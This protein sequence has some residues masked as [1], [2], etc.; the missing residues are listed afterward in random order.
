MWAE[1]HPGNLRRYKHA[2]GEVEV[3][4]HSITRIWAWG[5]STH[6][7]I[8]QP[9]LNGWCGQ[10]NFTA[11]PFFFLESHFILGGPGSRGPG[12]IFFFKFLFAVT[13]PQYHLDGRQV[14]WQ[15]HNRASPRCVHVFMLAPTRPRL[16]KVCTCVR[17]SHYTT[18]ALQDCT[19]VRASHYTTAAL[20][21]V[22]RSSLR[23][24]CFIIYP[25]NRP[26]TRS[27]Q[28]VIIPYWVLE[29]VMRGKENGVVLT[30]WWNQHRLV[31]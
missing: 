7:W 13:S 27:F 21:G 20:Q 14:C 11:T 29:K 3:P 9:A 22:T 10:Y 4:F 30:R 23:L 18:M 12:V 28:L 26:Q 2:N 17:A 24:S 19:F 25:N 1:I 6:I 5:A 16:S 8:D 15:L 31:R